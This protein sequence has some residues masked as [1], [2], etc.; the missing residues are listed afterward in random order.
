MS[1]PHFRYD[2]GQGHPLFQVFGPE[3]VILLFNWTCKELMDK[4]ATQTNKA[5]R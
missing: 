2:A 1:M 3:V 4:N 5:E